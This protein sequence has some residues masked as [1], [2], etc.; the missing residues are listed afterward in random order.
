MHFNPVESEQWPSFFATELLQQKIDYY[1]WTLGLLQRNLNFLT[2]TA[3][4][5]VVVF[6]SLRESEINEEL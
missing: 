4:T 1:Q 3:L 6:L 5:L 2:A